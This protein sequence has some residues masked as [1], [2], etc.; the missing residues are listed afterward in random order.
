MTPNFIRARPWANIT[1]SRGSVSNALRGL[2][3]VG[4]AIDKVHGR[5]YR[6]REPVQWLERDLIRQ[7]LGPQS[8]AFALEV[9]DA[10]ES[11]NTLFATQGRSG[12]EREERSRP[13]GGSGVANWRAGASWT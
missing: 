6:L 12:I 1:A 10:V 3:K 9:L 7:Y 4:L 8:D 2:D 5:G 11:T 13:G